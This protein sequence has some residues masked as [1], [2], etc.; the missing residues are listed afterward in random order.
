[1]HQVDAIHDL[2]WNSLVA[3]KPKECITDTTHQF[4]TKASLLSRKWQ[5][6][7]EN[8]QDVSKIRALKLVPKLGP[9]FEE[10]K[11]ETVQARNPKNMEPEGNEE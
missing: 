8:F 3:S 1:M 4:V 5:D 10:D 7:V 6:K 2:E 9:L 11:E